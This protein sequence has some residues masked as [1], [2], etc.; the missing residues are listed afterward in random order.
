VRD[1]SLV[2]V[3]G[4]YNSLCT[5]EELELLNPA[6]GGPVAMVSPSATYVGLTL[7]GPGTE[8]GEPASHYP[9]GVQSFARVVPPDDVEAIGVALLARKL[10]ARKVLPVDNNQDYGPF[11]VRVFRRAAAAIGLATAPTV[12][13]SE[14]GGAH[15]SRAAVV[16]AAK[17]SHADAV[18]L[19]TFLTPDSAALIREL[20]RKLGPRVLLLGPDAFNDD[21]VGGVVGAAAEG[22]TVTVAGA[23]V[24]RLPPTGRRFVKSFGGALGATPNIYAVY[25]AQATDVMLDAIAR[26]DGTRAGVTRRLLETRVRNGILGSFAFTP[27]GDMTSPAVTNHRVT[28][29]KLRVLEVSVPPAALLARV[30]S[31]ARR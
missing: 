3:I 28:G 24:D 2:G 5:P 12:R 13:F 21:R 26:S 18:F 7:G 17:R 1:P 4:P 14:V 16:R 23:P 10:G 6:P 20:R 11:I 8:P 30:R 29:G 9:T 19:G 27:A 31:G 22:M 25:G 15:P